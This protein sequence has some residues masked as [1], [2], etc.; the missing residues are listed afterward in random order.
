[1][2]DA[3]QVADRRIDVEVGDHGIEDLAARE[4]ARSA[5]QQHHTEAAIEQRRLGARK[6]ETMIGGADDQGAFGEAVLVQT[7]QHG[8]DALIQGSGAGL[9]RRHV[10]PGP[11][12]VGQVAAAAANTACRGPRSAPRTAC[13]SRRSRPRG[14]TARGQSRMRRR[15]PSGRRRRHRWCRA[16]SRR[17]S[18]SLPHPGRCAARRS[19]PSSSR[20]RAAGERRAGRSRSGPAA[21]RK[22]EHAVV[23]AVLARQ[24]GGAAAGAGRGGAEGV[25]KQHPL[26]GQQLDV[27]RRHLVAVRLH[28]AARVVGV[29]V[30]DV[31]RSLVRSVVAPLGALMPA[32]ARPGRGRTPSRA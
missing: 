29:D 17:R 31:R 23:V 5:H 13:A 7:V 24:Q 20:R 15:S 9:E 2:L 19:T 28:V 12:G 1:M 8:P 26:I 14:R 3:R 22:P 18:R 16:R 6:R 32:A 30:E 27:R 25:A 11:R 10:L 4:P 21:V